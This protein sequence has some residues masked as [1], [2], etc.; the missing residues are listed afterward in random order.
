MSS[1]PSSP[2]S[3]RGWTLIEMVVVMALIVVLAGIATAQYRNAMVRSQEAV[4]REDLFRMRDAIDQYYADKN[5]YPAD[6]GALVSDG[7]VR[8][9][10]RDPFTESADTWQTT[11]ADPDPTNPSIA[12]GIY[13]VHS[14]SERTA[15]DGTPYSN[16]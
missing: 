16:W 3:V 10:P 5:K 13:N 1:R 4:L 8:E 7:Y 11:P 9:V 15:I 2:S 14:G 12:P 6:L